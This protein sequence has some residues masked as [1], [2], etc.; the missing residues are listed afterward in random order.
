MTDEKLIHD[1]LDKNYYVKTDELYFVICERGTY[2]TL[3][4]SE[5]TKIIKTI[6]GDFISID[7]ESSIEIYYKW[8]NLNKRIVTKKISDFMDKLDFKKGS[9]FLLK[10]VQTK[11]KKN[12][13][14][15]SEFI[16]NYFTDV[17]IEKA[18]IPKLDTIINE[19]NIHHNSNELLKPF[20]EQ[21]KFETIKINQYAMNHLNKWYAETIVGE[22]VNEILNQL[23]ITLGPR[24]W[25]VT[26]IGHGKLSREKLLKDFI[27][28]D[29]Y[30]HK[31]ILRM[32]D[33]WY[34]NAVIEASERVLQRNNYSN[35]FP[36]L[37]L[38]REF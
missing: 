3:S 10:K 2:K 27:L 4:I 28:E 30:H 24:N 8:F 29:E 36:S 19:F 37:N 25:I 38:G 13:M 35:T 12:E 7:N 14:F 23:V 33:K 34:E 16:E 15:T 20:T 31:H 6:F 22:K 18:L 1:F 17:Y 32:Y 21:L 11:F 5:F 9:S 26:W